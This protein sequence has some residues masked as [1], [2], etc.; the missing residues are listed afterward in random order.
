VVGA[1]AILFEGGVMNRTLY[2]WLAGGGFKRG[3]K[4]F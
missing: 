1:A 3:Y 4:F 2:R